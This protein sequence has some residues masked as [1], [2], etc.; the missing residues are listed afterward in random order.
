LKLCD[1]GKLTQELVRLALSSIADFAIVPV[2]D[3]YSVGSEGRMN[4]PSTSGTNWSWRADVK[5]FEG[6]KAD[7]KAAWLKEMNVLYSR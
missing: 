3:V 5:M 4:M 7:E 1:S 2:Q 6:A